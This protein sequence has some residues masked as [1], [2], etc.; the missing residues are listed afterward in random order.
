MRR[1]DWDNADDR[2]WLDA[3]RETSRSDPRVEQQ[4]RAIV[5][6]VLRDG[7]SAV[8]R[9]TASLDGVQLDRSELLSEQWNAIADRCPN[10]LQRIL[11]TAAERIRAFHE[12]QKGQS[13]SV[14]VCRQEVRPLA[15]VGIYVPGGRA[16]YPSTVLMLA[17]PAAVAG[18]SD[19]IMVTPPGRDG[20]IDPAVAYAARLAGVT[21]LFRIGGA[22][23][24]G[25][26][27]YGTEEVPAVDAIVGPGNAWVAAAKRLVSGRVGID[28]D[29]GPSEVCVV[30]DHTAHADWVAR[31]LIA[32]AEHDPRAS[33]LL[34]TTSA[35]LAQAVLERIPE[36]LAAE[37]IAV[38]EQALAENGSVCVVADLNKAAEVVNAYAPEH[39]ELEVADPEALLA[40]VTSAGA[41]FLGGWSPAPLGDYLAGPNHTLP[42]GGAARFQS[43]L[44]VS[45]F[46][47]RI[48]VVNFGKSELAEHGA[49]VA[50]FARAEGL[51]GHARAI[52]VRLEAMASDAC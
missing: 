30:A 21:R 50:T 29:A 28:L 52:E 10:D 14:G 46:E 40:K 34:V 16:R 43:G 3:S 41:V 25:A 47:K 32:Q 39:L 17:I 24:V 1:L 12:P 36:I 48:N 8:L 51:I 13:Y 26:L 18:V 45:A 11:K 19:V 9:L 2:A 22:Q 44:G 27:A 35:D 37:P 4:A 23:A 15:S 33:C 20:L 31:D 49:D 42:T 6:D 38:A 5:A 7:D